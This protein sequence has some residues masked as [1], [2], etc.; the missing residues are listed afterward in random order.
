MAGRRGDGRKIVGLDCGKGGSSRG[1]DGVDSERVR[2]RSDW[3]AWFKHASLQCTAR[4]HRVVPS[5]RTSTWS[6]HLWQ[7]HLRSVHLYLMCMKDHVACCGLEGLC[8]VSWGVVSPL[9]E[10]LKSRV[11]DKI[12][13]G[14]SMEWGQEGETGCQPSRGLG[15]EG[16][17]CQAWRHESDIWIPH[18]RRRELSPVSCPSSDFYT[19]ATVHNACD[20]H[21]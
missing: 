18:G 17:L 15:A 3:T 1:W 2:K 20:A 4:P 16:H 7:S 9:R 6:A 12:P 10:E 11:S 21:T 8:V 5:P 19:C 13:G 14:T